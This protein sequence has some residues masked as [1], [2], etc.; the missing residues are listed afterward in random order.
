MN[1]SSDRIST[2]RC[3]GSVC[4]A[5]AGARSV[6]MDMPYAT[7]LVNPYHE[8]S[9]IAAG[10]Q[11]IR[12]A[13]K[14]AVDWKNFTVDKYLFTH[15]TIVSSVE[16]EADNHTI[17]IACNDLINNN[18]NAWTNPVLLATFKTFVGGEN[19]LEH[20]QIPELSKGKILDAVARPLVYSDGKGNKANVYYVD[21]LVATNR[22]HTTL[23]DD[24][25][26]GKLTTMSMGCLANHITCSR[27]GK[28]FSDDE[29]G[30]RHIQNQLL[31]SYTWKDGS[32]RITAELCG[33]LIKKD[34]VWVGD[35]ESVEFIE[36]SWVEQPAFGG[37]ELNHYISEV[38]EGVLKAASQGSI[39]ELHLAMDDVFKLRVADKQ[40]MLT[41]RV[42]RA[43][44][45]R[46][47]REQL[48]GR[49]IEN[50]KV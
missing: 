20:V 50:F 7:V 3:A 27:C 12:T 36:A 24:I 11:R 23:V 37:A 32:Q 13:R 26:S 45:A 47:R 34:G 35:P 14:I 16:T 42:A 21:I 39:R 4:Q 48:I 41:L 28:V 15:V 9:R 8:W 31:E 10:G 29:D 44:I 1:L 18:G 6:S 40:G 17:K 19:Y 49:V 22:K 38:P 46:L 33:R 5:V 25:E 30:C 2:R 43:E